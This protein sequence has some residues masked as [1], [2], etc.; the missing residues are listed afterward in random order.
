MA[1]AVGRRPHLIFVDK[2]IARNV[3]PGFQH[4]LINGTFDACRPEEGRL[5]NDGDRP[6]IGELCRAGRQQWP[7]LTEGFVGIILTR[8]E[9]DREE[10]GSCMRLVENMKESV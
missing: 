6:V 4:P 8:V 2:E 3:A 9:R 10:A 5:T 7:K 1:V